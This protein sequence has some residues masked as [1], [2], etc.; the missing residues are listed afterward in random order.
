MIGKRNN[1]FG[2]IRSWYGFKVLPKLSEIPGAF[3][4]NKYLGLLNNWVVERPEGDV[5]S[6]YDR[7]W[8]VLII[9]DACR[10]DFYKEFFPEAEKRVSRAS[11]SRE[12]FKENY[13]FGEF[14]DIIYVSANGHI[15]PNN[16][17]R[18][19]GRDLEGVFYKVH[20]LTLEGWDDKLGV[21]PPRKVTE[22][23]IEAEK[24][25]L[26]KR[27]VVHFMQPHE[28]F[29][30]TE[31]DWSYEEVWRGEKSHEDLREAYKDNIRG[32]LDEINRLEKEMSGK[33]VIT[34]DHGEFL[35]EYGLYGHPYGVKAKELR[36]VPW[37]VIKN[38][39]KNIESS[40]IE[41][42]DV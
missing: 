14:K 7:D 24:R 40:E 9:L 16:F 6:P 17:E 4:V 33:V 19:T 38:E 8:D 3:S 5:F 26:S 37:H 11:H 36:E 22:A 1:V 12:Y 21:V 13:S 41:N 15:T 39:E 28:P 2:R 31:G 30:N 29:I 32:L 18:S 35:G 25:N 10:Y 23:A 20:H 42:I 27:K 34:A